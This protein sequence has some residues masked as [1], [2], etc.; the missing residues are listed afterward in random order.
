[1]SLKISDVGKILKTLNRFESIGEFNENLPLKIEI[2]KQLDEYN[3]LIN[4]GNKKEIISKSFVK[5][6]PG[7]YF[8]FVKE[9]GNK[10]K[11][12]DLKELPKILSFFEKIEIKEK[13]IT[14]EVILKHLSNAISKNEFIFFTNMLLALN[15]KIYH[16]IDKEK[17]ALIQY[18]YK[19]N[20]IKFY[21]LFNNLGEIEGELYPNRVIIYSPFQNSLNL[22]KEYS[23]TIRFEVITVLKKEI[24]PL[25][26]FKENLIDLKA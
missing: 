4:L 21:A 20:K 6:N 14:K 9:S 17:K 15:Q 7:K 13:N 11:I 25:F 16:Y 2:K 12:T 18:K 24:K 26:E 8:A 19:K 10:I 5:L 23:D 3:Y 1:M 22:I